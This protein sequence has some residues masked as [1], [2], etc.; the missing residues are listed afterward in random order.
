MYMRSCA[1]LRLVIFVLIFTTY[2]SK[3]ALFWMISQRESFDGINS[4]DPNERINFPTYFGYV[5]LHF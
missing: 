3:A 5:K 1:Y 2:K 4:A